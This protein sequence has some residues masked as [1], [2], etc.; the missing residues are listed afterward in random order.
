LGQSQQLSSYLPFQH[1]LRG[2]PRLRN[3]RFIASNKVNMLWTW[4]TILLAA[5]T[6]ALPNVA[7]SIEQ[8]QLAKGYTSFFPTSNLT[9]IVV[10][11]PIIFTRP[12]LHFAQTPMAITSKLTEGTSSKELMMLGIGSGKTKLAKQRADTSSA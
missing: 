1:K 6:T 9:G 3:G 7:R 12:S 8:R 2:H 5:V 4:T 10:Q 11:F